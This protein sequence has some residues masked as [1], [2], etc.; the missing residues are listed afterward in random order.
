MLN[1]IRWYIIYF[2]S[3]SFL[4]RL[5]ACC[6]LSL[7]VVL[8]QK[9]D[10]LFYKVPLL[11]DLKRLE[12]KG[13]EEEKNTGNHATR[14]F[15]ITNAAR[16]L[17]IVFHKVTLLIFTRIQLPSQT[18]SSPL[19]LI[20]R[21]NSMTFFF[22]ARSNKSGDS[23]GISVWIMPISTFTSISNFFSAS[24]RWLIQKH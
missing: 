12:F 11:A 20:K 4:T 18:L 6:N 7:W 3:I 22:P 19:A 13:K 14:H 1:Y 2:C 24:K 8:T 5:K 15:V 9:I 16:S 10:S 17:K 21:R 23:T